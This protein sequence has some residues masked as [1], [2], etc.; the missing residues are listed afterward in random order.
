[1]YLNEAHFSAGILHLDNARSPEYWFS[2]RV[3]SK[4][5]QMGNR[6]EKQPPGPSLSGRKLKRMVGKACHG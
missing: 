2:Q 1:M 5:A 4:E 6:K 3:S